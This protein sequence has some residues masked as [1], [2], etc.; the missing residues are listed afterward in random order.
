M[1]HNMVWLISPLHLTLEGCKTCGNLVHVATIIGKLQHIK[2]INILIKPAFF[3]TY[4]GAMRLV[5]PE[6]VEFCIPR[7]H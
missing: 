6:T 1:A 7:P 5:F 2:I 4:N 3:N